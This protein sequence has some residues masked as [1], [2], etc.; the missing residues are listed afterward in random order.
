[1]IWEVDDDND[2]TVSWEE[3]KKMIWRGRSDKTGYEPKKLFNVS[4]FLS[5][6]RD[7]DGHVSTEECM[8]MVVHHYGRQKL[9]EVSAGG[10]E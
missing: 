4:Q 9:D 3:F 6:D 5:L 1:M 10:G 7:G 2:G 8:E